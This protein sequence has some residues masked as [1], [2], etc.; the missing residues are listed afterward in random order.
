MPQVWR[1]LDEKLCP[2]RGFTLGF[3][4]ISDDFLRSIYAAMERGYDKLRRR[5]FDDQFARSS[6]CVG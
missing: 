6:R 1:Q 2:L 5:A 4:R 3:T